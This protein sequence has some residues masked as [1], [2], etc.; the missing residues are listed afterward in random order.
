[1]FSDRKAFRDVI[2]L[3]LLSELHRDFY[4]KDLERLI[5]PAMRNERLVI[6]YN[7][8]GVPEGMYSHAFLTN[9]ASEGYMKGTR[10]LQPEDWATDHK[11]GTLWVIDFIAPYQNAAKIARKVQD[12]LTEK[13]LYLYPKD[14][15]LWRRPAKGG[16][17]RWTPGVFKLINKRKK[18]GLAHAT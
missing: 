13:Y 3:M 12:D 14:G 11:Q 6:F 10:K 15:A 2:D 5:F 18:D 16:H 17:A 1:M 9:V 4:I 7:D 8:V